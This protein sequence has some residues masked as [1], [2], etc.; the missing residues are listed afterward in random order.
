M[1]EPDNRVECT[2]EV[3]RAARDVH[4]S[5]TNWHRNYGSSATKRAFRR[6]DAAFAALDGNGAPAR[7][8]PLDDAVGHLRD[9]IT[10]LE[11][12]DKAVA[13]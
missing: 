9:A 4:D 10:I 5:V 12:R 7:S 13:S 8:D 1:N 2:L 11:R 3:L 6:L